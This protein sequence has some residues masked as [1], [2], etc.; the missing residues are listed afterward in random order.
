MRA[1]ITQ[2]VARGFSMVEL[3]V[4][5]AISLIGMIIIFQVFEVSE[6]IKRTTTSGGDAQQN[7]AI[8]LY[9]LEQDLTNAGMGFNDTLIPGCQIVGYDFTRSPTNFPVAPASAT[10]PWPWPAGVMPLVPVLISS[11]ANA[12]IP[13]KLSVFYGSSPLVVHSTVVSAGSFLDLANPTNPFRVDSTWGWRNGDLILLQTVPPAAP[14]CEL[15]EVTAANT[16]LPGLVTRGTTSYSATYS[17]LTG[18]GAQG[19]ATNAVTPRFNSG[20]GLLSGT[21]Y[22]GG[23]QVFNLGN[24]YDTNPSTRPVYNTYQ[25]AGN[26]LVVTSAFSTSAAAAMADN[27]VQMG[28]QYG[29]DDGI[30]NGTVPYNTT[31]AVNDGIVDRFVP[32]TVTPNWNYV[33]AVRFAVVARS[34]SPEK[35]S[36]GIVGGPCDTT[37]DGTG[38]TVD[39]RPKWS[40][41]TFDVSASG[42]PMIP[43]LNW[44]CYRYRVFET[45]IPVRNWI[46]K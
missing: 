8:A 6:G 1:P 10:T 26:T 37:T 41:G 13:D 43:N 29:L 23:A 4:A 24:L 22:L 38:G 25:I 20:A 35:P 31:P 15:M 9:S 32:G 19:Q 16:P 30:G 33:I 40:G 3:L 21:S 18:S 42:D 45:T 5:M 12:T 7:G 36:S 11:G 46:W 44:T 39:N 28:A 2:I 27:I 14:N 17:I 34:A